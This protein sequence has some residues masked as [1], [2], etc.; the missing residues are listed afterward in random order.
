MLSM[1]AYCSKI[2]AYDIGLEQV[3]GVTDFGGVS[4]MFLEQ[5]R[6]LCSAPL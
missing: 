3:D 2:H 4:P 1:L 6:L 5:I